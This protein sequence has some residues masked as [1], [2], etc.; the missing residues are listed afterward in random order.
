MSPRLLTD[1]A[2]TQ[3]TRFQ[4]AALRLRHAATQLQLSAPGL[5]VML[6]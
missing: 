6:A 3:V 5:R 4:R 1:L 2:L